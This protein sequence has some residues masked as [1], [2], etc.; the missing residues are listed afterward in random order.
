M[1]RDT[2]IV[3]LLW[4]VPTVVGEVIAINWDYLPEA[5]AREARTVDDAFRILVF[6]AVPVFAF[7]VESSFENSVH[8][9]R[10]SG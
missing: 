1:R 6:L 7:V 2:L 8:R 9:C 5:A 4:V 3:G 10:N